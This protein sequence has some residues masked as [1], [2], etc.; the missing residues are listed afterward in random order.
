M[1]RYRRDTFAHLKDK[2]SQPN[3][4]NRR[5][6]EPLLFKAYEILRSYECAVGCVVSV[7]DKTGNSIE[8]SNYKDTIFFCALCRKYYADP[9]RVWTEDEYPCTGMHQDSIVQAKHQGGPYIYVCDLGFIYWTSVLYSGGRQVGALM[10]GRLLFVERAEAVARIQAL[11]RG[12]ISGDEAL[13]YLMD[14]PERTYDEIKSMAQMLQF[15]TE[16]LINS[17]DTDEAK[18]MFEQKSQPISYLDDINKPQT[19]DTVNPGYPLDKERMLLAALRRGDNETGRTILKE[20][21]ELISITSPGNF[22]FIQLRA[23][24]L[25]VLLSREILTV[26]RSEDSKALEANNR[27]LKKIQESRTIEALTETMQAIIDRMARQIFSFQGIRHASAL[28]K[29]ERFIWE[30]Y[31]RKLCLQEVADASGL[32]APYFSTIFKEEMGENL[33]SY[34][35]RLRVEKAAALLTETDLPLNEIAWTCGFEDQSWF[36]KIFKSYTKISPRKYREQ[37]G[38]AIST[39]PEDDSYGYPLSLRASNSLTGIETIE[40]YSAH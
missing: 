15:C 31:T 9:S 10:A 38:G 17:E 37:G 2:S 7:L 32:S 13:A 28:R 33:S 11:G 26:D 30:N 21:L 29:A 3:L 36:S 19:P 27:Y 16:Y 24:E 4:I 35:N 12:A 23:I 14:I 8:L 22:E 20:L 5:E 25:V 18:Y 6:I 1:N 34:L 40:D 39:V